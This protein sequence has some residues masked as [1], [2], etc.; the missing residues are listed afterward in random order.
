MLPARSSFGRFGDALMDLKQCLKILG[1][2]NATS[3]KQVKRAYRDLVHIWH[4]DRFTFDTR[5]KIKAEAKLQE[6]NIAYEHLIDFLSSGNEKNKLEWLDGKSDAHLQTTGHRTGAKQQKDAPYARPAAG[7][8]PGQTR[9]RPYVKSAATGAPHTSSTVKYLVFGTLLL[10]AAAT[11]FII[12]YLLTLDRSNFDERS[13]AS[14]L[15]RKLTGDTQPS[16]SDEKTPV[17]K[18]KRA[19]AIYPQNGRSGSLSSKQQ[20]DYCEIYLKGGSIIVAEKWWQEGTMIMYKTR[21]GT[22]GIEKNTVAKIIQR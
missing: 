6:I 10:F 18:R 20:Y 21:I 12:H 16:I 5:L 2:E 13:P 14:S 8:A 4:P 19:E 22:M 1:L 15:L 17:R 7:K 11:V 3:Q 9:P